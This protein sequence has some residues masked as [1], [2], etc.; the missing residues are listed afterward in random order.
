MEDIQFTSEIWLITMRYG[1]TPN[2]LE[3]RRTRIAIYM[4]VANKRKQFK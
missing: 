1:N 4:I 2:I 3:F